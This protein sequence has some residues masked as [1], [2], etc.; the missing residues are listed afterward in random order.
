MLCSIV[1]A[2]RSATEDAS[3]AM[4]KRTPKL[5]LAS[6]L[7]LAALEE[8]LNAATAIPSAVIFRMPLTAGP[9]GNELPTG[10]SDPVKMLRSTVCAGYEIAGGLLGVAQGFFRAV[11]KKAEE[12]SRLHEAA[13]RKA[14]PELKSTIER[15][16]KTTERLQVWLHKKTEEHSALF[17]GFAKQVRSSA[18]LTCCMP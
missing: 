16:G 5:L 3:A 11:G 1:R 12:K 15:H 9:A 2:G 8:G 10:Y 17:S 7:A 4:R 18:F 14:Q 6:C 13:A